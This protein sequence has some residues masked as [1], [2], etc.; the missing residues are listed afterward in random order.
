M[1]YLDNGAT[2]FPKPLSVTNA[3]CF[4]QRCYGA[5]PGRGG[6]SMALKA[7]EKIFE[8]RELLSEMF[9]GESERVAFTINCTHALNT[10]IK[11]SVKKGDH[12]IISSLEHNSV[13]RPV[14]RLSERGI[15]TYDIAYVNPISDEETVDNF[16]RLIRPSTSLV[17]CT[18]V[19]N[20]FGTVLPYRKIAKICRE[21]GI[22]FILDGA[23]GAG[24]FRIDMKRDMIDILCIPCH[25]GL[26]GPLGTGAMI[27]AENVN[28]DSLIE[29]GTG[30]FSMD[31]AQ[32]DILPDKLESGTQNLPGIAG[33]SEGIKFIK[34][35]G[36]ESEVHKKEMYLANILK[37]DLSVI[38]NVKLYDFMQGERKSPMIA[39]N[40]INKHSEEISAYLD[41]H[42]IAVR[43]GYHCSFLAH[44]NY[45]TEENGVVRVTPGIFNTKKDIKTLSFLLNRFAFEDKMC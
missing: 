23:Q 17:V 44:S 15:A 33:V 34:K 2:S 21:K 24:A 32:P 8:A 45:Y 39:F 6:H 12:I 9:S 25:K 19:S 13:L 4:Y 11:G 22:R 31:K 18:M 7:G 35:F 28:I 20:V 16:K 27:L 3:M 1:I 42:N 5:N 10:A 36:G 38:K 14:H 37:E 40:I 26:L 30:S 41:K 29:G 43:S